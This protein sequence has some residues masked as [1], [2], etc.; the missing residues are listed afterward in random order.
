MK[1]LHRLMLVLS[2][3]LALCVPAW[4]D[5]SHTITGEEFPIYAGG[6]DTGGK[7]PLYFLDGVTDL[8]Y[9]EAGKLCVLAS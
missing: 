1:K 7:I 8:P 4:A 6:Q 5:E 3:A 9:M 2:M